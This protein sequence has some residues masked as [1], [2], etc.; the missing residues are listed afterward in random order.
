[1]HPLRL[2][3]KP[4]SWYRR[5][6]PQKQFSHDLSTARPEGHSVTIIASIDV[7]T[8]KNGPEFVISSYH[9]CMVIMPTDYILNATDYLKVGSW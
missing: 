1:M 8:T 2:Y 7:E 5:S 3:T 9:L 6:P 4:R